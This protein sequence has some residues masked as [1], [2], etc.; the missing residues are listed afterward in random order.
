MSL[1]ETFKRFTGRKARRKELAA[2][3]NDD[4]VAFAQAGRMEDAIAHF[5]KATEL[6]SKVATFFGPT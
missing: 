5:R 4:G 3:F 6:D 1:R 2:K